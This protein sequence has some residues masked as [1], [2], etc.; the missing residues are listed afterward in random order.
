MKNDFTFDEVYPW[1]DKPE[2]TPTGGGGGGRGPQPTPTIT[3]TKKPGTTPTKGDGPGTTPTKGEGPGTTPT[4]GKQDD[5]PVTP[6]ITKANQPPKEKQ[7]PKKYEPKNLDDHIEIGDEPQE[8]LDSGD[9]PNPKLSEE[10]KEKKRRQVAEEIRQRTLDRGRG[11]SEDKLFKDAYM[12]FDSIPT[13]NYKAELKRLLENVSIIYSD[14]LH[15]HSYS[16]GYAEYKTQKVP[17]KLTVVVAIDVSGSIVE[18]A[19]AF[20]NEAYNIARSFPKVHLMVILFS[21]GVESFGFCK[22]KA[23]LQSFLSKMYQAIKSGGTLMSPVAKVVTENIISRK[24]TKNTP[25][26]YFTDGVIE[27]DCTLSTV[28]K[29]NYIYVIQGG[30]MEAVLPLRKKYSNLKVAWI[31]I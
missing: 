25:V 17:E 9:R 12:E 1:Q 27:K 15:P 26:I 24:L 20:L 19:S 6:T 13:V 22:S 7:E 18:K 8:V 14:K 28:A 30:A 3:T 16:Y 11:R 4:K 2:T 5:T 31:N 29:A 23:D 10:Q 21:D